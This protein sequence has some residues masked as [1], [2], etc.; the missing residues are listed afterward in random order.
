[1]GCNAR[2]I[3]TR[4]T[5]LTIEEVTGEPRPIAPQL[6]KPAKFVRLERNRLNLDGVEQADKHFD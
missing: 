6:S 3:N 5:S 1:L 4:Q 2:G